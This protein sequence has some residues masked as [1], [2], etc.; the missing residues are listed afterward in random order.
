MWSVLQISSALPFGPYQK[1]MH[2]H[3]VPILFRSALQY[4]PLGILKCTPMWSLLL[5]GVHSHVVL[6]NFCSALPYGPN[7]CQKC[8]PKWSLY[9]K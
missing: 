7:H 5:F 2:S 8:T 9:M 6:N 1:R 4:G 3:V